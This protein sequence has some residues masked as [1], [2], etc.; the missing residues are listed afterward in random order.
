MHFT[1]S[2]SL[3]LLARTPDVLLTMLQD[4]DNEWTTRNEGGDT[5]SVYD[6]IGHLIHGELTDWMPRAEI[7]LSDKADK[8]FE[9]FD[10]FAQMEASQ[11]KTL[12][13]LL[14]EFKMLRQQNLEQ[15]RAKNLTDKDLERTGIHPAFG[16][17]TLA[18][19]LATWTVHDLNHIAQISRVMAKQYKEAVGPWVAYLRI[20]QS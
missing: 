8:R 19:L 11:G 1:L 12:H 13:E 2:Q 18:Q 4:L 3:D 10:R 5:W 6:V 15:L 14:Q 20:L 9:P 16:E 17:V 7:I